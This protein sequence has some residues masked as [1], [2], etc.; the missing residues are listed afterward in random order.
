MSELIKVN[1]KAGRV[2][3]RIDLDNPLPPAGNWKAMKDKTFLG[4]LSNIGY[5]AEVMVNQFGGDWRQMAVVI[6]DKNIGEN[7]TCLTLW[8]QDE[9]DEE[10]VKLLLSASLLRLSS[11]DAEIVAEEAASDDDP[12]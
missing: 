8:D 7:G 1:F 3:E 9:M 6:F 12:A 2:E 5:V 11:V 4:W 10:G